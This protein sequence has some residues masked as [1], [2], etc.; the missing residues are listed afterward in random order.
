MDKYDRRFGFVKL[1]S[2]LEA[3]K[4]IHSLHGKTFEGNILKLDFALWK[5][6]TSGSQANVGLCFAKSKTSNLDVQ[7]LSKHTKVGDGERASNSVVRLDND[8]EYKNMALNSVL[9]QDMKC[10]VVVDTLNSSTV[11][12]VMNQLDA[13]GYDNILVRGLSKFKYLLTFMNKCDYDNLDTDLLGL[14]FLRCY[15]VSL[16]DLLL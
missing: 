2:E 8:G 11:V 16:E 13:L 15:A 1:H 7:S 9:V 4:M 12:E 14:G 10:S 3:S 6:R 5:N